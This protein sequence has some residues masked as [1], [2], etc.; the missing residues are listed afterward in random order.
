MKQPNFSKAILAGL[1]GT[2]VM[3]MLVFMAP[4]MGMP[5]MNIPAMLSGFMGVPL[6]VGWLAHAMIG[7]ILALIYVYVFISK[8]PGTPL[9]KGALY[10]LIPWLAAQVMVN[11]MMGAGVFAS[12]TAAPM[13]MVLG[14]LMGHVVYGAVV[15][16]VYGSVKEP[17]AAPSKT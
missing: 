13:M 12:Q 8:L 15:G 5:D 6:F 7:T 11:P 9:V 3:T 14:S 10:G 16:G 1:V 2:A 4:L 17:Q